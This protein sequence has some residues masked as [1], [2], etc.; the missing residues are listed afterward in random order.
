VKRKSDE[1]EVMFL[2]VDVA[3][4]RMGWSKRFFIALIKFYQRAISPAIPHSCRYVP[5]CSQY[6]IEAIKK[7]G[8]F[9]GGLMAIWRILRCN[10]LSSGGYDPVR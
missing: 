5:T 7:Y 9:K 10:P 1:K 6:S 8:V 2:E 4:L 3:P